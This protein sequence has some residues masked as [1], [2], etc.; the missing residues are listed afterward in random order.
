MPVPI[1][2]IPATV[3]SDRTIHRHAVGLGRA[4]AVGTIA[5]TLAACADDDDSGAAAAAPQVIEVTAIDFE[6]DGL[7]DSVP[8]GARLTLA[9]DAPA[10]LHEIVAFRLPDDEER[11]GDDLMALP[12][13]ELAAVFAGEPST[14]ILTP[15]GGEQVDAVGDGTLTDAGRYLLV[16]SIP[17]GVSPDAYLEAAAESQG[18]PPDAAGGPPHFV[19]GMWAELTVT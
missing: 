18:G 11:S 1:P 10:E 9:N 15:P 17:T 19:H 16:C 13:E 14:V 5:I 2:A 12:P 7:P 4:L 3:T 6:F 8:A